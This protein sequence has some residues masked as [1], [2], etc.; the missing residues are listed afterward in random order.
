MDDVARVKIV[1]IDVSTY[2]QL[3]PSNSSIR[4]CYQLD[5]QLV[6]VTQQKTVLSM[7]AIGGDKP[8]IN[9][10]N[11]VNKHSNRNP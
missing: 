4:L 3:R 11:N 9:N 10:I 6:V 5:M 2:S 8:Y 1:I 7:Y